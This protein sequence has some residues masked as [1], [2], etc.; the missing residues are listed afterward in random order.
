ML[1]RVLLFLITIFSAF[2]FTIADNCNIMHEGKFSYMADDEEI[3]V[4]IHDTSLTEYHKKGTIKTKL[5][6]VNS[7]EYNITVLRVNVPS[8]PMGP[9]DEMNVKIRRVEGREIYYTATVKAVSWDGKFT[10]LDD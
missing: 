6:W 3:V 9:G 8:F 10:K 4:V 5:E 7:C 2:A 1:P